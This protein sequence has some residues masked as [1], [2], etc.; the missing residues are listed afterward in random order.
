V[1]GNGV[2]VDPLALI[3]EIDGLRKHKLRS[4]KIS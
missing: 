4:P 2:V 1:I 3:G